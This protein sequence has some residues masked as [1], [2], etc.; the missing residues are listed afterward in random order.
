MDFRVNLKL[1]QKNDYGEEL[2]DFIRDSEKEFNLPE[3]DMKSIDI[4]SLEVYI[5]FLDMLWEK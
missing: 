4:G 2:I 3:K 5:E 1:Q